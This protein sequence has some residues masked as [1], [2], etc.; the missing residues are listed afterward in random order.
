MRL[1]VCG[2]GTGGH[3]LPALAII[4]EIQEYTNI[5]VLWLIT[6]RGEDQ[7]LPAKYRNVATMP[8]HR[9]SL[10]PK[11]IGDMMRSLLFS[12]KKLKE[13][14]PE[15]SLTCGGYASIPGVV[16]SW[17]LGIPVVLCEVNVEPGKAARFISLFATRVFIA[18]PESV[19]RFPFRRKILFA[20]VPI[21]KEIFSPD[22]AQASEY[23]HLEPNAVHLLITGGS[24]GSEALN[25][26]ALLLAREFRKQW[27]YPVE[28]LHQV[29]SRSSVE[30]IQ[31]K[32][33]ALNLRAVVQPFFSEMAFALACADIALA[34]AG[35]STVAELMY[36]GVPS[37]F[38]PYP[39]AGKHQ[40]KNAE[41]WEKIG[42]ARLIYQND[43][44][45][46]SCGEILTQWINHPEIREE[47]ARKSLGFR[48]PEARTKIAEFLRQYARN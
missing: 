10:N 22:R 5:E 26:G 11:N 45:H 9:F 19:S 14:R 40:V 6:R 21:R 12:I 17:L 20:G 3:L 39:F 13:F 33:N 38:I 41:Y 43:S 32:W 16:A 4:Q 7:Y 24:Q 29:G 42:S 46:I 25:E 44:W 28:I 34:R 31:A 27:K 2:G 30:E 36:R 18:Y 8:L 48:H 23:F 47:V 35:A 15:A 1:V 37:V